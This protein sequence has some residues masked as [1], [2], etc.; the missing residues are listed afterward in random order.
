MLQAGEVYSRLNRF[1]DYGR[2]YARAH[3]LAPGDR[4]GKLN[5][6]RSLVVLGDLGRAEVLLND[7]L[8]EQPND[9]DAWHALARLRKWSATENHVEVLEGL[10]TETRDVRAK[11]ALCY[12]LHKELEDLGEDERAMSWLQTGART[13]RGTY[14]YRVENDVSI[15][16]AI[17]KTF[18]AERVRNAP[19]NGSGTGAIFVIGLPRSGTTMVDRTLSAH[20]QVQSLGELRDLTYAAMTAGV[21]IDPVAG[22]AAAPLPQPDSAAVGRCYMEAVSTYRGELPFFVDKAPMNFLYAGL[23][24]LALPGARIVLLRRD[25]MDSC[26]AIYKTLFREGSPFASN[27][28]DLGR[29][30]VAWHRLAEHWR[31]P[32]RRRDARTRVTKSLV[33]NQETE[34][35]APTRLL[36]PRVG[37]GL[38][39]LPLERVP[40]GDSERR[41]GEAAPALVVGRTMEEARPGARAV[42]H[43]SCARRASRS[44]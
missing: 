3:E 25:P 44:T 21:K 37:S 11:V 15:M 24:R 16:E 19:R 28:D 39:G 17:A 27:L 29:Y 32:L 26:L 41:A 9:H 34:S 14:S 36:R 23:I 18:P 38:H 8:R 33:A 42:A 13:L 22:P 43:A 4:N 10:A 2:C 35:A 20:P 40:D 12:A 1:Q 6:A 7:M 31:K 5:L 30:Y